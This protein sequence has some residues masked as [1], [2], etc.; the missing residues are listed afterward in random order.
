MVEQQ[1]TG[2]LGKLTMID[3]ATVVHALI[4]AVAALILYHFLFNR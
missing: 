3:K 1:N 4:I 2:L